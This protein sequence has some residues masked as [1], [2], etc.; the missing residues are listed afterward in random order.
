MAGAS[1]WCLSVFSDA[2]KRSSG[3]AG[4]QLTASAAPGTDPG[5]RTA[6]LDAGGRRARPCPRGAYGR[7]MRIAVLGPLQVEGDDGG[8]IA[9]PGAK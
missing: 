5:E 1:A 3:G 8:P 9:V 7:R 6:F 2:G 4:I